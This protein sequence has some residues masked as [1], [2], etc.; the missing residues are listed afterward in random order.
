MDEIYL[1][2][3]SILSK[4]ID[5]ANHESSVNDLLEKSLTQLRSLSSGFLSFEKS[6]LLIEENKNLHAKSNSSHFAAKCSIDSSGKC[7]CKTLQKSDAIIRCNYQFDHSGNI[8]S[9]HLCIPFRRNNNTVAAFVFDI[10]KELTPVEKSFFELFKNLLQSLVANKMKEIELKQKAREQDVLNQKLFAQSIEIDQ[11]NIEIEENEKKIM[12]QYEELQAVEEELRQNNE[13]LQVLLEN[14]ASQKEELEALIS[15]LNESKTQIDTAHKE[16]VA[17]IN[18]AKTIQQALLT[19]KDLIDCYLTN[20]FILYQPKNQVGGDFYYIN[21]I[22]NK[23]HIAAADCTGHGVAGSF[24]TVLG[25]TYLHEAVR[26]NKTKNPAEVLTNL[27]ERFKRTFKTFGSKNTNGLDIA[28]CE[29]NT[30]TNTLLYAGANSP[31]WIVRNHKLIEYK[32]TTNPVGYYPKEREFEFQE[33]QLQ[34][35]DTIYLFSDGYRDQYGGE[36][37][38][39]KISKFRE[40]LL[41]IQLL[42]MQ[43][44]KQKLIDV[45]NDWKGNLAQTDDVL[46]LG[47]KI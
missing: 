7:M 42:S 33:I 2:L 14:I 30:Q 39:F 37:G 22:D 28:L 47:F 19:S 36:K 43:E 23:L 46:V 35:N 21:K 26:N 29:L 3:Q 40:L 12:D 6:L 1:E 8:E 17:S 44:Q 31:V 4:V 25:I 20:Y 24:L 11:K 38:K 34:T 15:E 45:L 32:A 5:T 27:R 10:P 9:S 18:Y 16:M 13:E 41:G